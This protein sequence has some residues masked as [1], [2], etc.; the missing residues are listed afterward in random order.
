MLLYPPHISHPPY[1]GLLFAGPL[2][3]LV[4]AATGSGRG[5]LLGLGTMA[6]AAF[7]TAWCWNA[8]VL[9]L[10]R[11]ASG[12]GLAFFQVCL[13]NPELSTSHL[14]QH[15]LQLFPRSCASLVRR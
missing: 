11:L 9:L 5:Q 12:I 13:H 7:L 2:A 15:A 4:V 10:A 1:A 3:G 14:L 8:A 6:V